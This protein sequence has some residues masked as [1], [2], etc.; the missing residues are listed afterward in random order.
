MRVLHGDE[1]VHS[2]FV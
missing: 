1:F 2:A